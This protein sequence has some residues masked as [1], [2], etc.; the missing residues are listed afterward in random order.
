[1]MSFCSMKI[2]QS[3]TR[4]HGGDLGDG[5]DLAEGDAGMAEKSREF[6]V[7]RVY[8]PPADSP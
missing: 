2:S 4:K 7:A 6:A 3:I 5:G 1:M 8:L